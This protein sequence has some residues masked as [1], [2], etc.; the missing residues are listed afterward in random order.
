MIRRLGLFGGTFDP[1]HVGHLALAEWAR[2]RLRLDL[3]LFVPAGRPPHK[4]RSVLSPAADRLA[5]TRLA[6]RGHPAFRVSTIETRRQGPSFTV[7]TLGWARARFP[8]AQVFLLVGA[9]SLADL[10]HWHEPERIV[11]LARLA[12]AARP[13]RRHRVRARFGARV[14]E[15][16]NPGLEVSSSAIRARARA[17]HSIRYLVP[18][19]VERYIRRHGLYRSK[20]SAR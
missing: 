7:D 6:V 4:R 3:V 18:E 5:M 14:V 11:R 15:L 8:G 17:G 2:D 16:D 1:P 9:D 10:P 20:R 12:V 19:S 13:G